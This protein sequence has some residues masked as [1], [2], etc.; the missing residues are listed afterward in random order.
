MT[1]AAADVR[2]AAVRVLRFSGW[3]GTILGAFV[4]ITS[5]AIGGSHGFDEPAWAVPAGIGTLMVAGGACALLAG[6]RGP[7]GL[8]FGLVA[9]TVFLLLLP[10]G[11]AVTVAIAVI[12]SQTWPQ[13]REY[14]GLSRRS[15]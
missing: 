1:T 10:V 11:T 9:C 3:I 7:A 2:P 6:I 12:S 4:A 13:L 15:S 5:F 14:Y 8:G